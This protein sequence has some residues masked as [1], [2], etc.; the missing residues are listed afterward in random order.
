MCL[1]RPAGKHNGQ[2]GGK[3]DGL[4]AAGFLKALVRMIAV[5]PS[6]ATLTI[7]PVDR[8]EQFI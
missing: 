7:L 2:S 4:K 1:S 8:K 5:G 3:R 6:Q